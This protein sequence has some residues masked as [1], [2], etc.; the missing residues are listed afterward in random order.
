MIRS[1]LTNLLAKRFAF[2]VVL[3]AAAIVVGVNEYSYR[4]SMSAF[5]DG[6]ALTDDRVSTARLLQSLTDAEAGQRGYLLTQDAFY[7]LAYTRAVNDISSLRTKVV[8]FLDVNSELSATDID[9][10]IDA[11]LV[12]MSSTISLLTNGFRQQAL[13]IVKAGAVGDT[14]GKFRKLV[15]DE[16]GGAANRQLN[17]RVAHVSKLAVNH[18]VGILLTL[19]AVAAMYIF[20]RQLRVQ[21]EDRQIAQA[22]LEL[23]VDKRTVELRDLA[24]YL[25]TVRELEKDHLARELHDELGALLTVAKLD[26]EGMRKRVADMPELTLRLERLGARLNEVI[27]LKRRMVEDMRPSSLTMLGLR[28]TLEQHCRDLAEAMNIPFDIQ[29]EDVSLPAETEL[30]IFR[31]VQ[32]ALT[33]MAKYSGAENVSV[34][35]HKTGNQ[36]DIAVSDDGAGFD[37]D[38]ALVGR[39]GLTGMRYRIDSVGG[40]MSVISKPGLGTTIRA[41]ITV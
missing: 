30:V 27:V 22:A 10:I 2:Q 38:C 17:A 34:N 32:E 7:L 8:P 39:H 16:L 29:I 15:D 26:L 33:N 18:V 28:A 3:L 20:I 9:A 11:R 41:T 19:G 4:T 35:L 12:E 24:K 31:F 1:F 40:I 5:R 36:L 6:I 14:T 21:F 25:Q 13:D 37:I 23:T